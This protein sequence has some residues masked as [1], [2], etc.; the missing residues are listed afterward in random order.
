[1]ADIFEWLGWKLTDA[2][3]SYKA[4]KQKYQEIMNQ[5]M[6]QQVAQEERMTSKASP[7]LLA[8]AKGVL[9]KDVYTKLDPGPTFPGSDIPTHLTPLNMGRPEPLP[10]L[11]PVAEGG[12]G[13]DYPA[14][15]PS[16]PEAW[17]A[18]PASRRDVTEAL[19]I[20]T[21]MGRPTQAAHLL[22]RNIGSAK[23]M[24]AAYPKVFGNIKPED[25]VQFPTIFKGLYENAVKVGAIKESDL[26]PDQKELM[27]QIT[28]GITPD[29][30]ATYG[31]YMAEVRAGR[32]KGSFLEY[33]ERIGKAGATQI[34]NVFAPGGEPSKK[35]KNDL[36]QTLFLGDR[37]IKEIGLLLDTFE[38]GFLQT[39]GQLKVAAADKYSRNELIQGA[40]DTVAWMFGLEKTRDETLAFAS[41]QKE[42]IKTINRKMLLWRKMITGVAG[43]EK[44][45]EYIKS[46]YMN[47]DMSPLDFRATARSIIKM[48]VVAME[49][50]RKALQKGI[51]RSDMTKLE[52]QVAIAAGIDAGELELLPME[53]GLFRPR[54]SVVDEDEALMGV[55]RK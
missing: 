15:T 22:Q 21:S 37:E 31:N 41:R 12:T 13:L 25:M 23:S 39:F 34:S 42:F 27:V 5:Q 54:K 28:Q 20:E 55:R 14:F 40:V 44:E 53:E 3:K 30:S 1:M 50:A 24:I 4:M 16:L 36:Q 8:Q 7:V 49:R 32:F 9:P 43:G 29:V 17:E 52:R 38:D 48:T 46:V 45:L 35:T 26:P 6:A 18:P 33:Q 47:E 2:Q 19:N 51:I 10:T 11:G